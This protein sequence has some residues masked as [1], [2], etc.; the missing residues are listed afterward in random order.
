VFQ[1]PTLNSDIL[2][3]NFDSPSSP[4]IN[5]NLA[6]NL[7]GSHTHGWGLGWYPGNQSSAMVI[8][9]P[10][11]RGTQVFTDSLTDWSNFRSHVFFCKVR[12]ADQG[13]N[14][15]ETQPFTR[16]FANSD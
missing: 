3:I 14:Q 16:N 13:Y 8:K 6:K 15:A 4:S 1:I 2:L 10:A 5:I 11:A 7:S 12:G 9:D